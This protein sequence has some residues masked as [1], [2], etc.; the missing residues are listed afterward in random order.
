M[1][2]MTRNTM[3]AAVIA[4]LLGTGVTA[5][6]NLPSATAYAAEG[7][8]DLGQAG[9]Y[10][11]AM[12][13][14]VKQQ[15]LSGYGDGTLKPGQ[16]ITR[17][18]LAKLITMTL[19]LPTGT[20][21]ASLS[22]VQAQ[23]WFAPYAAAAVSGGFL[24]AVNGSFQPAASVT[25]EQLVN[26]VSAARKIDPGFFKEAYK[27][28]YTP[29]KA[30]T[31]GD[32]AVLLYAAQSLKSDAAA[33]VQGIKA[34]NPV[35]LEITFAQPL[36]DNE[37]LLDPALK[38]FVFDNGLLLGNIPQL[39]IG[40]QSTYIVPTTPQ[41]S[42][43]KYTLTYQGKTAG[44]FEANP[45]KLTLNAARQ[46][47]NDTLEL[48]SIFADGVTDY[49]NIVAFYKGKRN[50]LDFALDGNQSAQGKTYQIVSSMRMKQV[51]VTPEGG[52]A[53]IIATYVPF[54]QA[55]DGRQAPKFR[56]PNGVTLKAGV[57]YT[58]TSDWATLKS[59]TFTAAETAPLAIQSARAVDAAVLEITL[60]QD[61]KDELFASR[62]VELIAADGT[63]LTA[64]Y[65]FTSRKGA[66]GTFDLMNGGKLAAGKVY[67]VKP[68][69][70]WAAAE[71]VTLT[72]N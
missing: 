64:Q 63:K 67:T 36:S 12:E 29:A 6:L 5:P 53:P 38:N 47:S 11:A 4:A 41:K 65:R 51:T 55:T 69:G 62:S 22:D 66:V 43:T 18:E 52:G 44:T 45:N 7:F 61:P 37:V 60:K 27:T 23:D 35:T 46:V 49:Q 13:A 59:G 25:Q 33:E 2:K 56:L 57:K 17:A 9:V 28:A 16:G 10:Q 24:P 14:L 42:G 30:A 72:A 71:N 58:V 26:A 39:K 48:D 50:G 68:V 21:A 70:G 54:T 1:N 20:A 31:R 40:S 8:T 19:S 15:V 3:Y 32:A 34:L